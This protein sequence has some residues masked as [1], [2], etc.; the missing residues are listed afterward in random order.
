MSLKTSNDPSDRLK[1][2]FASEEGQLRDQL[3]AAERRDLKASAVAA[4]LAVDKDKSELLNTKLTSATGHLDGAGAG[5]VQLLDLQGIV[6]AIC[7]KSSAL[8][9]K[10]HQIME[11]VLASR[12]QAHEPFFRYG[13]GKYIVVF[14][15]TDE[16]E[17]NQRC[18]SL[19][20]LIV[21]KLLG[22]ESAQNELGIGPTL[23]GIDPNDLAGRLLTSA[24]IAELLGQEIEAFGA[25]ARAART[26]GGIDA[27]KTT[28]E[29]LQARLGD[30]ADALTR[31]EDPGVSN[32][33]RAAILD[34]VEQMTRLTG[35][36]TQIVAHAAAP[37]GQ[38]ALIDSGVLADLLSQTHTKLEKESSRISLSLSSAFADKREEVIPSLTAIDWSKADLLLSYLPLWQVKRHA[39]STFVC[40][41]MTKIN[42]VFQSVESMIAAEDDTSIVAAV[43]QLILLKAITELRCA[44]EM[45]RKYIIVI[46][47][48]FSSLSR[49]NL[50]QQY[51]KTCASLGEDCRPFV[52]FELIYPYVGVS[53]LPVINALSTI[54]QYAR[55]VFLRVG[56]DY[57]DFTDL[58]GAA[59]L[60]AGTDLAEC[61]LGEIDLVA[62][63]NGFKARTER[64]KLSC[65][66]YGVNTLSLASIAIGAG[67]D[68]LGGHSVATPIESLDG[69][70]Q[71]YLENMFR[72][73]G[74][75]GSA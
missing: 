14:D 39:I 63:I 2:F 6:E 54:K 18:R 38:A 20:G 55:A 72:R 10:I 37:A 13:E 49:Q 33:A 21:R 50:R 73:H 32:G 62:K 24:K 71:Y 11:N 48:H 64:A 22:E 35:D 56:I 70:Q 15:L 29:R 65:L 36:T 44:L 9:L 47:V 57:P 69:M 19:E 26:P 12:L 61:G 7:E 42:S 68:Y 1:T 43:D 58:A 34:R 23:V 53:N 8:S 67:V 74:L 59:T 25:A 66:L 3:S 16:Q 75:F 40:G 41:I 27:V 52:I 51:I 45:N 5:C 17:A 31:R 46:P 28:L 4:A 30:L 60:S